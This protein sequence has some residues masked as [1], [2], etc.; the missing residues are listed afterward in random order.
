[1]EA[2]AGE[3]VPTPIGDPVHV[4]LRFLVPIFLLAILLQFPTT[5][6]LLFVGL[7]YGP[8]AMVNATREPWSYLIWTQRVVDVA[9]FYAAYRLGKKIEF[10]RHYGLLGALAVSGAVTGGLPQLIGIVTTITSCCPS[11]PAVT[12]YAIA[13]DF[14]SILQ[15]LVSA[16]E[17]SAIPLA[18]V[19]LSFF[20]TN[21]PSSQP[22]EGIDLGKWK[23]TPNLGFLVWGFVLV[24]L[25]WAASGTADAMRLGLQSSDQ[26]AFLRGFFMASPYS[27]YVYDLF[28][29]LVFFIAFYLMG[30]RLEPRRGLKPFGL[31]VFV[32]GALGFAVGIAFSYYIRS[33]AGL[34]AQDISSYV[35]TPSF[36]EGAIVQ[37]LL[38]LALG[39]AAASIGFVR[40]GIR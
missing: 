34:P 18:G 25:A 37:G 1:M 9:I 14:G 19:A 3:A 12:S 35:F 8:S 15:F 10:N 28:Y 21:Y 17:L 16:F 33:L 31:L 36:L 7:I 23:L 30:R 26:L 4:R 2:P 20:R 22:E 27:P 13:S 6:P 39:Y 32:A 24:T 5:Y 38:V 29:P 11:S 40:R